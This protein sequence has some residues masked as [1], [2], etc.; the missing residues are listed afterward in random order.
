[1]AFDGKHAQCVVQFLANIFTDALESAAAWAVGV[2]W[3]V[4]DQRAGKLGG[5]GRTLG[6]LPFL[7][8]KWCYL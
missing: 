2:V 8:R 3:F 1:M 6:L 7:G 5:Q 4:M